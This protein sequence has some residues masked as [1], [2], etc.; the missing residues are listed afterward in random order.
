MATISHITADS[1]HIDTVKSLWRENS[2]YLGYFPNGA[3]AERAMRRQILGAF[4]NDELVGYL[5]F[6]TT[7]SSC[8]RITHLCVAQSHRGTG[9]ARA[10]ISELK[11]TT[12]SFHGIGLYCRRDFPVWKIWPSLGF[13]AIKE[14]VGHSKDGHELTYFWIAHPHKTL[15]SELEDAN[16]GA[17]TLVVDANVFYDMLDPNRKEADE[18]LG[19]T[20]DWLQPEIRLQVTPELFNEIQRNPDSGQRVERMSSARRYECVSA[21]SEIFSNAVLSIESICGRGL[22]ERDKADQRQ[23]AW[24]VAAGCDVFVTRDQRLLEHNDTIYAAHGVTVERPADVVARFEEI[25]NEHEY[26]RD[27]LIGTNVHLTRRSSDAESLTD[28][29]HVSSG[30]EKKGDLT[31]TLNRVFANPDEFACRVVDGP[32]G[33]PL[34]LY[35]LD[36]SRSDTCDIR[37]FRIRRKDQNTRLGNTVVRAVL[38][39]VVKQAADAGRVFTR[40][41]DSAIVPTVQQ[42]LREQR[43]L[44]FNGTWVK[45]TLGEVI[46]ASKA[47]ERLND[48]TIELGLEGSQ[49]TQNIDNLTC[50]LEFAESEQVLELESLIWPGKI[51]GTKVSSFIVPIQPDWA[52]DL[53]DGRLA[54]GRLWAANTDLVLNPNSVYYRAIKPKVLHNHGRIL[55]YVSD[56]NAHGSKMIRACS[57]LTGV[58]IGRPKSLF[59]KFRRFGVYEWRDILQTAKSEDG[60]L[61]ALE[62][63]NTELFRKPLNWNL[64]QEVL[65]QHGKFNY[66]FPSP[67][68]IDD[69]LFFDLYVAG[70][71]QK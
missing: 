66:T 18:S 28:V 52:T 67:V 70:S 26:Q 15:F 14:K 57:Q 50:G 3:F 27:R 30:D 42:A 64:V 58:E 60:Q 31:R 38:A 49:L 33:T 43:I 32:D 12:K 47:K 5:L 68:E 17:L 22:S 20:A 29:F 63:N 21:D 56:G 36:S 71:S 8:V 44:P 11:T 4:E 2:D 46:P 53:F 51:S 69:A 61:M 34:V 16:D 13:H 25:R 9:V 1:T 55:W 24:T 65:E 41:S 62:F 45:L 40:I 39:T 6:F 7:K 37:L 10:L 59:R 54:S 23:L 48:L 35:V 19:L